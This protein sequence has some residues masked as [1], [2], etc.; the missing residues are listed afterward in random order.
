MSQRGFTSRLWL[1][2]MLKRLN[3]FGMACGSSALSVQ[4]VH[5]K[6]SSCRPVRTTRFRVKSLRLPMALFHTCTSAVLT[7]AGYRFAKA[8]SKSI[9]PT[10]RSLI[11]LT[12]LLSP[13]FLSAD[14]LVVSDGRYVNYEHGGALVVF[15]QP[16]PEPEPEAT[17]STSGPVATP[18]VMVPRADIL[19]AIHE[20][21][22]RYA[23]DRAIAE[24]GLS[25]SQWVTLFR[26]NIQI[27]SAFNPNAQSHVGAIGL[28]QL[29]PATARDLGVDPHDMRQNLDGSARYLLQMLR[30]FGS[31]ELALAAYNAGPEAVQRHGGVPPYTETQG[32]VRKVMA[33]Y[34][35][36]M[37][38]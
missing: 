30:L 36:T 34:H 1:L 18:R 17:V 5:L 3:H 7:V 16:K 29:M 23:S 21:G 13:T 12:L 37:A 9:R 28:G 33:V 19:D 10:T 11:G 26:S 8:A 2:K 38:N 31:R 4:T 15:G 32:H 22:F 25:A 35:Q 20:V 27:E 14:V 24:A 6:S